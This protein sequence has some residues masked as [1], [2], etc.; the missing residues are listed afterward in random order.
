M[1]KYPCLIKKNTKSLRKKLE[2]IGYL[3]VQHK[4]QDNPNYNNLKEPWL[5]CAY[6]IYVCVDKEMY[7]AFSQDLI[8]NEIIKSMKNL[9]HEIIVFTKHQEEEFLKKVNQTI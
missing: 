1:F 9:S 6:D 5:L 7:E 8:N 2:N 4:H 3:Y